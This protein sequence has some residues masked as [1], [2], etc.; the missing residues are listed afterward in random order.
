MR[1][2]RR[3][4]S[5]VIVAAIAVASLGAPRVGQAQGT[6]VAVPWY[7]AIHLN[8]FLCTSFSYNLN[9][10]DSRTNTLRVFDFDDQSFKLD[11]F[12]LVA[13]RPASQPRESGFRADI[14]LGSSIPRV[15]A[16][17][18]LFRDDAG[19]AGDLD[20]QQAYATYVAP[21]G[22]GLRFD[23]G[24][25]VTPFGYELIEG[26]D[27]WN[28]NATRSLLF[29]YAIP[30]THTGVRMSYA[31]SPRTSAALLAVNGWDDA[32]DNN[33]AKSAGLQLALTPSAP[34]TI[35]LNAMTGAER[36]GNDSDR[37]SLLDFT[38]TWKATTRLT[39]GANG[40]W[41]TEPDALGPGIDARWRGGAGYARFGPLGGLTWSLR[42][43]SFDD[44]DGARTGVGQRLSEITLTP[45]ARL[46]ASMLVRAD[47]RLDHSDHDVFEKRGGLSDTQMTLLVSGLY[48][49]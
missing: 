38:A 17:S 5:F 19:T 20:L 31:F 33:R 37:R 32:R 1:P 46:S 40:D 12:E 44:A 3:P 36:A 35:V 30:F 11:A 45:E 25:F 14:V 6:P 49:F 8:G 34:F 29:G 41:G 18:G 43:E 23:L 15:S 9:R 48:G 47:L 24:K 2:A 27:G 4:F 39:L 21:L 22:S 42:A 26:Y 13:Q 28:D 16:A 7:E 10:P